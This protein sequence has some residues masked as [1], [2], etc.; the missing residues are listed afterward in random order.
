MHLKRPNSSEV[1]LHIAF[2]DLSSFRPF[3]CLSFGSSHDCLD[4]CLHFQNV[5]WLR[6]IIICTIFQSEDLVHILA[7]C[8]QHHNWHIRKF[9]YLLTHLK[10]IQFRQHHIQKNNVIL[11]LTDQFQCFLTVI[12][13]VHIHAILFQTEPY[14]L[15]NQFFI[16]YY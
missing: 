15:H 5:K 9:T 4:S 16:V 14:S 13:T 1:D 7:F 3:L 6:D 2:D 10:S 12:G 11:I 8:C